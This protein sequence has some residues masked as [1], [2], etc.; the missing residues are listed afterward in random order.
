M[1]FAGYGHVD[2]F[3]LIGIFPS[4]VTFL[5]ESVVYRDGSIILAHG[6]V[7]SSQKQR[8]VTW[9]S[10]TLVF[11]EIASAWPSLKRVPASSAILVC[12]STSLPLADRI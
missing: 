11:F 3:M 6:F 2:A 9:L 8:G 4:K 10:L 5:S 12:L 7:L 1:E